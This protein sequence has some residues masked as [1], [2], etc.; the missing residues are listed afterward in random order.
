VERYCRR[1]T[2]ASYRGANA[3]I[4]L[5]SVTLTWFISQPLFVTEGTG[6]SFASTLDTL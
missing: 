1:L 2:L 4:N 6:S 5:R 3:D